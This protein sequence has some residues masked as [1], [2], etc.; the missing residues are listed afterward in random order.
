MALAMEKGLVSPTTML[1][2]PNKLTIGPSTIG[3]SHPHA[4]ALSVS[5]SKVSA[6]V[7]GH[8]LDYSED[9][10]QRIM[11]PRHF[12]EIRTT[13]GGPA[14]SETARALGASKQVLASRRSQWQNR[15]DQLRQADQDLRARVSS[16]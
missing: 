6:A 9:A 15:R 8:S 16:L 5:L 10:L 14:P 3:D 2:T 12:V 13:Y 4:A 7:L 1:D 11:S